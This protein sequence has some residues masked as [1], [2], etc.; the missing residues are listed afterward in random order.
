MSKKISVF[1][2]SNESM[3]DKSKKIDKTRKAEK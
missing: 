2:L 1:F 3:E